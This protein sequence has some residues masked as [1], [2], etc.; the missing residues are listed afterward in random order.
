MKMR[1]SWPDNPQDM[2]WDGEAIWV[3]DGCTLLRMEPGKTC[4]LARY[5]RPIT[6]LAFVSGIGVLA[7]LEGGDSALQRAGNGRPALGRSMAVRWRTSIR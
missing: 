3:A 6:A 5:E 1:P 7:A 4:T 2:A